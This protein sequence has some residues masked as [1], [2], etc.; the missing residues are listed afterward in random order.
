M[1]KEYLLPFH[2]IFCSPIQRSSFPR[3]SVQS[4]LASFCFVLHLAS[5]SQNYQKQCPY[6]QQSFH[7][8]NVLQLIVNKTLPKPK[9]TLQAFI[10]RPGPRTVE[11]ALLVKAQYSCRR[12]VDWMSPKSVCKSES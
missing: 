6:L 12:S 11:E 4:S 8:M 3:K 10:F 5:Y 1:L 7:T 2:I 9:V